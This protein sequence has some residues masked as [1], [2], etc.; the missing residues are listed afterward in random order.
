MNDLITA[1]AIIGVILGV[2]G[3]FVATLAIFVNAVFADSD[4][5]L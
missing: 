1:L 3:L 2:G 5:E 4:E